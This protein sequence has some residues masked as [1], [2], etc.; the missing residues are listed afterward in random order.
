MNDDKVNDQ[1]TVDTEKVKRKEVSLP[2]SGNLS[3]TMKTGTLSDGDDESWLVTYADSITLLMAFFVIMFSVSEPKTDKYKEVMKGLSNDFRGEEA[4]NPR[5]E[6]ISEL[7][8]LAE[9]HGFSD[10][11]TAEEVNRDVVLIL[12][13]DKIYGPRT[14][15]FVTV[16]DGVLKP[17]VDYIQLPRLE[18]YSF[19]VEGHTDDQVVRS[20]KFPS[21]WELSAARATNMVRYFI[22][23]GL[24]RQRIRALAYAETWPRVPNRDIFDR[25]ISENRRMNRRIV[26][27]IKP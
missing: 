13:A 9:K 7:E 1:S 14:A 17:I 23:H 20:A 12:D 11:M 2:A 3:L 22:Y 27:R 8:K 16:A 25:P 4:P 26:I 24:D 21:N 15:N 18:T 10:V 19:E 6:L 5:Q